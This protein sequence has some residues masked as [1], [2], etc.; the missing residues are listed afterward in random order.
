MDEWKYL[1]SDGNISCDGS[2]RGMKC[3]NC[4]GEFGEGDFSP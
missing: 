1:H 4:G 2:T 3:H